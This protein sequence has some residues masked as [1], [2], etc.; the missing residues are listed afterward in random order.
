M[1]GEA[2]LLEHGLIGVC[3]KRD[4]ENKAVGADAGTGVHIVTRHTLEIPRR[5]VNRYF[6]SMGQTAQDPEKRS[7]I[8]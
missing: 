2:L 3:A 6:K 7:G 5:T 8:L 4:S 1:M